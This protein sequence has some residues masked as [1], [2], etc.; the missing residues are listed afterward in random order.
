MYQGRL[1]PLQGDVVPKLIGYFE[2]YMPDEETKFGV[3]VLEYVGETWAD[4]SSRPPSREIRLVPA[5]ILKLDTGPS[6][7]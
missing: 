3:L 4:S 6:F 1:V 2:G 5:R 7:P